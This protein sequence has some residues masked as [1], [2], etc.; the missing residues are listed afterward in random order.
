MASVHTFIDRAAELADLQRIL[1]RKAASLVV[2]K[3]RRRIGKSRLI[4]EFAKSYPNYHF[5]GLPPESNTSPQTQRIALR[6]WSYHACH[7]TMEPTLP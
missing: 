7:Q 1:Y 6:Y 4:N 2:I 5:I 3:G